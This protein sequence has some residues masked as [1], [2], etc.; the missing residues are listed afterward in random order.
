MSKT[1]VTKRCPKCKQILPV[2]E[3]YKN[4]SRYDGLRSYC[5][6]CEKQYN[7]TEKCKQSQKRY[8]QTTK[9]K[10]KQKRY[11]QSDKGKQAH[12]CYGQSEKGKKAQKRCRQ[13]NPE[14]RK[15]GHKVSY[16]IQ[17]GKMFPAH[18]YL[19]SCGEQAEHYHHWSYEPEHYLHVIPICQ[20]CHKKFHREALQP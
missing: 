8:E 1:I 5:K 15:A 16:A 12:R 3:F 2:S 6:N 10:Q 14:R 7:Q 11:R 18:H 4:R 13:N 19:C 20:L 17:V 9:Y